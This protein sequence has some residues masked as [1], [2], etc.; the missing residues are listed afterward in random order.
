M[1]AERIFTLPK[2]GSVDSG[3]DIDSKN[4]DYPVLNLP[5]HIGEERRI[6]NLNLVITDSSYTNQNVQLEFSRQ[7]DGEFKLDDLN[8]QGG[9]LEIGSMGRLAL[10]EINRTGFVTLAMCIR[11]S[12]QVHSPD[13]L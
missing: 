12:I 2:T 11:R 8:Q 3:I 1:A 5:L 4:N 9:I 10:R 13:R 7:T 6:G